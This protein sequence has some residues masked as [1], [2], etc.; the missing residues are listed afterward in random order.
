MNWELLIASACVAISAALGAFW[1]LGVRLAA[2]PSLG[3]LGRAR[4][5]LLRRPGMPLVVPLVRLFG[6][7]VATLRIASIRNRL[8]KQLREGG[9][10]WG[11]TPDEFIATHIVTGALG[12]GAAYLF[13]ALGFPRW[14]GL[15]VGL[16]V[17]V[18]P[19]ARL[20]QARALRLRDVDRNLPMA[21]DLAA[22][23]MS[24]GLD[25]PGALSEVAENLSPRAPIRVELEHVL[26]ELELGHTRHRAL[27]FF[28]ERVPTDAV[29]EFV[30][31]VQQAESRGTPLV[32]VLTIQ[33]DGLR[34][35]RSEAA[36]EAAAKAAVRLMIPLMMLFLCILA[37]VMGPMV[38]EMSKG[39]L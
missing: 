29:R 25:F 19:L 26:Y 11:M 35:R 9:D 27:T 4:A 38:V 18:M 16:L 1:L 8:A 6:A 39:T 34:A 12:I 21:I 36:E 20:R 13:M 22:M 32:E 2:P 17:A 28:A 14:M 30:G 7:H 23:C 33:A 15:G 5:E 31:A 3:S 24:A 10:Y 37:L